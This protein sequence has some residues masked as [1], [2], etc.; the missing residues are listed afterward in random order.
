MAI[1]IR[2]GLTIYTVSILS[3]VAS[4][5]N[6]L[7]EWRNMFIPRWQY[8]HDLILTRWMDQKPTQNKIMER[9]RTIRSR[10]VWCNILQRAGTLHRASF[11]FLRDGY[12]AFLRIAED[13]FREKTTNDDRS[14]LEQKPYGRDKSSTSCRRQIEEETGLLCMT[15][16]AKTSQSRCAYDERQYFQ[17]SHRTSWRQERTERN[18][19]NNFSVLRFL[20]SHIPSRI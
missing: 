16:P 7:K 6:W 15:L 1:R 17:K 11:T 20:Q 14:K 9:G 10:S 2:I 12:L 13:D 8:D 3:H 19:T 5:T 4:V 18:T